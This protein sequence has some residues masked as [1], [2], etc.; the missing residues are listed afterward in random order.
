[1]GERKKKE[2]KRDER[3]ERKGGREGEREW[4]RQREG[5]R[6]RLDKYVIVNNPWQTRI[7]NSKYCKKS[8]GVSSLGWVLWG[9]LPRRGGVRGRP[10]N[11]STSVRGEE[12]TRRF[13]RSRDIMFQYGFSTEAHFRPDLENT[14]CLYSLRKTCR[15][16]ESGY[17]EGL[18]SLSYMIGGESLKPWLALSVG[19]LSQKVFLWSGGSGTPHS[20]SST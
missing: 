4:R 16:C 7:R 17:W 15:V 5:E 2:G 9:R 10:R 20:V 14:F 1:M 11:L 3:K 8:R 6:E 19:F 12:K 18:S 13:F